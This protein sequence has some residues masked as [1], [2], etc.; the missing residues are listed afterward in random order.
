MVS[1]IQGLL[2]GR[3]TDVGLTLQDEASLAVLTQEV[4]QTTAIEGDALNV[5][6]VRFSVARRQDTALKMSMSW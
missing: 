1:H 2:M 3:L 4:V 5:T 6:S